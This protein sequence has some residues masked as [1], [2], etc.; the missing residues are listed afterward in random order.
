MEQ[1]REKLLTVLEAIEMKYGEVT[2]RQDKYGYRHPAGKTKTIASS[3]E[4]QPW[5]GFALREGRG[6]AKH[7]P[8][9]DVKRWTRVWS[10][11]RDVYAE[12]LLNDERPDVRAGVYHQLCALREK[13]R[14]PQSVLDTLTLH[15]DRVAV[16]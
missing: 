14:L 16:L 7:W 2:F 12:E 13:G 6:A 3:P 11:S 8:A 10:H 1:H 9:E 4:L 15:E 5:F